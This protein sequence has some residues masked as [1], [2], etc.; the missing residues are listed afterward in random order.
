MGIMCT[1]Y[2]HSFPFMRENIRLKTANRLSVDTLH[3]G[4]V[5]PDNHKLFYMG[6]QD[7]WFTFNMFDAQAWYTRDVILGR[8]SMPDRATMDK[9]WAEWRSKEDNK[10]ATDEAAIRFQADYVKHLLDKSDY[11]KFDVEGVVQ[12]FLEW[13]HNKHENIM[14]FRDCSHKS[15]MTGTQAPLHTPWLTSFDDSIP[16]FVSRRKSRI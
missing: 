7:Q 10:E 13:E 15:V 3:D 14:T 4:I 16:A 11:K 8:I 6:M 9:E 2:L 5:W 1:G 12:A